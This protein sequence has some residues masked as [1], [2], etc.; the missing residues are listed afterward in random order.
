MLY[1][2]FVLKWVVYTSKPLSLHLHPVYPLENDSEYYVLLSACGEFHSASVR[3][4][5]QITS[6]F[7]VTPL[8][9]SLHDL[10]PRV[11]RIFYYQPPKSTHAPVRQYNGAPNRAFQALRIRRI[12][13]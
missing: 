2:F 7:M 10:A 12:G 1:Y 6:N 5:A 11:K 4:Q 9:Y 3:A 13:V 8:T